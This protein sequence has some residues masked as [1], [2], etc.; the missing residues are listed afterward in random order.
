MFQEIFDVVSKWHNL[1][2]LLV[3]ILR[4]P[5]VVRAEDSVVGVFVA[6]RS[7]NLLDDWRNDE[8]F[9]ARRRS[10]RLFVF[11]DHV[12]V[13]AGDYPVNWPAAFKQNHLAN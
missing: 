3:E 6:F 13:G 11:D 4:H 2:I 5:N 9:S 7:D 10:C 1:R 8:R 12:V